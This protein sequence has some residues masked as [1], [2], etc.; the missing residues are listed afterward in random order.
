MKRRWKGVLLFLLPIP[1][2]IWAAFLPK[3]W[4]LIIGLPLC[5]VIAQGKRMMAEYAF[6]ES[7]E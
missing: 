2:V 4:S 5:F 6:G 7:D 1:F 3:P